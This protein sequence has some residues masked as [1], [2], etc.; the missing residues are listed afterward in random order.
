MKV[1]YILHSTLPTGGATKAFKTLLQGLMERGIEP[2]VVMPDKDG[3]YQELSSQG[4]DCYATTFRSN[5]YP[6]CRNWKELLMFIPRL[7]ARIYVIRRARKRICREIC[8]RNI[9][10][11]HTNVGVVDLGFYA[12]GKLGIPHI[13]HIRE[14][15][16]LDFGMHYFPTKQCFR[17]QLESSYSICITRGIQHHHGLDNSPRSRVIYDG[18]R[19]S[20]SCTPTHKIGDYLLYAGRLE[21]TKGLD[22]LLEAYAQCQD[23]GHDL[24]PL[25]IAGGNPQADFMKRIHHFIFDHHLETKVSFLGER[26]D[27]EQLMANARALIVPSRHEGFGLCMPE[28][29]FNRCLVI[30]H[31]TAGTKE[32]LDNG[33]QLSGH[34]IALRFRTIDQLAKLLLD[35]SSAVPDTYEEMTKRSFLVVNQLYTTE[36]TSNQ[37]LQFYNEILGNHAC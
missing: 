21:Y 7:I 16:D 5:T 1:A 28:A 14:Y 9:E 20:L 4:I 34:E 18:I 33:A 32:Q 36:A 24:L 29:M 3:I 19:P 37:T 10:L 31:D 8:R 13:Y 2:F 25:Q 12:S 27:I 17:K 15:A 11:I 26:A 6:Y 23:S 22:I 30:A 35:V